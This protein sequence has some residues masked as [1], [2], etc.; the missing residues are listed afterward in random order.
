MQATGQTINQIRD[1]QGKGVDATV[2][3]RPSQNF[4]LTD[5]A[6]KWILSHEAVTVVIPGATNKKHVEQN[7]KASNLEEISEILPKIK[8][9]YDQLIR[10]D[11]H[12]RW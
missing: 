2:Y 9:V 11:V 8:L 10:P 12:N 5:L 1:G 3:Y 7:C 4:S 6:L